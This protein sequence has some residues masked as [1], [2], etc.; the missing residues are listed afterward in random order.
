MQG[1]KLQ[2]EDYNSIFSML[3]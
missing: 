2:V 1:R 3:C